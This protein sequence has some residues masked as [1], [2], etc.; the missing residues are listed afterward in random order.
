M[1]DITTVL[2]N[3][4]YDPEHFILN[5]RG[6]EMDCRP[7]QPGGARVMGILN[8]TPDSFSDG[9]RYLD[10]SDALRRTEEMLEHGADLIDVGGES[11][12]PAGSVYGE[13]AP[14][15]AADEERQRIL[16]VIEAITEQFPEAIISVDTYKAAVARDALQ[17]GAAIINDITGL[18]YGAELAEVAAAH[19]APMIVMHSVG[20]PGEMSHAAGYDDVIGT[21]KSSLRASV[22]TA[23]TAGVEGIVVDPGFGFGKTVGDNLRLMAAIPEFL[24]LDRPV[25][26]GISRKSTVGVVRGSSDGPKPVDERLFGSLGITAV[27]VLRGAS[28]VRTHD[29]RETTEMLR[30]LG[31]TVSSFK[32][33]ENRS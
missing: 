17:A 4:E 2:E 21:V 10:P 8:V 31:A 15:V 24:A 16:P 11:S 14:Q 7:S 29:V 13:G 3:T 1:P 18:R 5:C 19:E 9:G 6:R 33:T 30:A 12:R 20:R 22:E 27:A 28:I 25:V 23:E 32:A 26:V